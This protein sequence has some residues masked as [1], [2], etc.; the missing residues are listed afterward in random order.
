L[1]S[2]ADRRPSDEA[3][4]GPDGRYT[5]GEL[6]D[7][8]HAVAA[9]LHAGG[10]RPAD[11]VTW[12]LPNSVHA[13]AT[14]AALWRIGAVSNPVVTIYRPRELAFIFA[15]LRP[16][17]IVA[18]TEVRGRALC[19]EVDQA[20]EWAGHSPAMR[21]AV[22]GEVAGWTPLAVDA[23]PGGLPDA[24]RPGPPDAPC[25]V[26]YT[27]GTTAQPKGVIHSSATLLQ[28]AASMQSAWGLTFRDTI[29]M[30]SPLTHI[31]GMLQGL[32]IPCRVGA[33]CV[34]M[35]RWDPEQCVDLIEQERA[36]YM[37][38]ATPFLEGILDVYRRR[39]IRRPS[40]LQFCCGGAAV[41]PALIER[42]DAIGIA[43][44]RSWGL[45]EFP[46]GGLSRPTDS[47]DRRAR[48]DGRFGDGVEVQAVDEAREALPCGANGELRLRGP[49]RMLGYVDG[50]LNDEVLDGDGWVY[51]GDIGFVD[52]EG[53][54]TVTGR[55][56]D[57]INRGGEK[58][59]AREVEE[60]LLMHERIRDAAVVAV[61]EERLGEQVCAAVVLED[62]RPLDRE[63]LLRFLVGQR[64]AQQKLPQRIEVLDD[65]PRT[66]SG[67]V[68]K[69]VIVALLTAATAT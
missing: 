65:L 20:L 5:L 4:V 16:V 34:L 38:G 64:L 40:L 60:L 61:P 25:L 42:V 66:A 36:T 1:E 58:F 26:L 51:S 12:T 13:V 69:H 57:I 43:A 41:S 22:G 44:H 8:S 11:V 45:T 24:L 63:E 68:Q 17:A 54:V 53:Y 10:V 62:D 49:E 7:R 46:S 3:L 31:T 29:L 15:Q 35:D 9:Q 56:K 67:K 47:L 50:L 59:S 33:R 6:R 52:D 32:I 48:T 30:A 28:E 55:V 23:P 14:A 18:A 27:S 19:D 37:A 2:S 39:G 21:I